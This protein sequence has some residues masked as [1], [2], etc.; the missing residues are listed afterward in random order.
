MTTIDIVLPYYNGSRY[1]EEQ[2]QSILKNEGLENFDI[3]FI[4]INDCSNEQETKYLKKILPPKTLYIE[5]ASNMGVIK[6]IEIGLR[7]STA[8]YVL[9]CDQDDFWLPNKIRDTINKLEDFPAEIPKL[10]FTDLT[11]VN[12]SLEKLHD[13]MLCRNHYNMKNICST[14]FLKNIVTGCTIGMNRKLLDVSLPF[15]DRVTMHDHWLACCAAYFGKLEL[16]K[17][18]TILYRQHGENQIGVSSES[19]FWKILHLSK[20][21]ERFKKQLSFKINMAEALSI[22]LKDQRLHQESQFVRSIAIAMKNSDL[23]YLISNRIIQGNFS[24]ILGLTFAFWL[25]GRRND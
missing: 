7:A 8:V 15:P 3:R 17:S 5:N 14:I 20:I 21:F 4:I 25:S 22:R 23:V 10:V 1:I 13:S 9:L 6:S 16:I 11:I 19:F 24:R 12:D 18:P 2:L